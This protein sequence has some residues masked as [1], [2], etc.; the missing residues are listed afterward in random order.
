M[1]HLRFVSEAPPNIPLLCII[2]I[3]CQGVFVKQSDVGL[4]CYND[5]MTSRTKLRFVKKVMLEGDVRGFVT[6]LFD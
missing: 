2:C 4:T 5:I 6:P 3:K 1:F